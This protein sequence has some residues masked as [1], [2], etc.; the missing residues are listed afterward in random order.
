MNSVRENSSTLTRKH[1]LLY[2]LTVNIALSALASKHQ[3][4]IYSLIGR[5]QT[6]ELSLVICK[7]INCWKP[8]KSGKLDQGFLLFS[9]IS[10]TCNFNF[11]FK[12]EIMKFLKEVLW[13]PSS[14]AY[15]NKPP[16]SQD[17]KTVGTQLN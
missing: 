14:L 16:W 5:S 11:D 10:I 4:L 2:Q 15:I 8:L 3:T 7:T 6:N 12:I 1:F 17:C 9:T 13:L